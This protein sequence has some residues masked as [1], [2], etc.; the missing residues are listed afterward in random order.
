MNKVFLCNKHNAALTVSLVVLR[1]HLPF[2][3][4]HI[5]CGYS[6]S[7]NWAAWDRGPVGPD[8]C[9]VMF[10]SVLVQCSLQEHN[11]IH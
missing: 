9:V 1:I 4:K 6:A 8:P 10:R 3:F 7:Q 11:D 2:Y 5:L